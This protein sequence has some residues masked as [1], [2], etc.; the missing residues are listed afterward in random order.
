MRMVDLWPR[1]GWA[2]TFLCAPAWSACVLMG[3]P[4]VFAAPA[5]SRPNV[6]FIA[7][8]DLRPN[9][10]CYGDPAAITP[11]LDRLAARGTVFLRAYCQQAVCNPS[12]QSLLSGRRPDSIRVWGNERG[13]HF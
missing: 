3:G 13:S 1:R 5:P 6:L 2:K 10:G 11:H 9:L 4:R 12:R 8:D 7:I